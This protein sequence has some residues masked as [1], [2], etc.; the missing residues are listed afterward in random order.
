MRAVRSDRN[1]TAGL[2]AQ[3]PGARTTRFDRTPITPVVR[4]VP[5]LTV[6]CLANSSRRCHLRPPPSGPRVVTIAIRPSSLGRS[7]RNMRHF[8]ISVKAN[9]FSARLNRGL[10]CFARQAAQ[11]PVASRGI[12]YDGWLKGCRACSACMVRDARL[13]QAPHHEGLKS[14]PQKA[15]SS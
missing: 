7:G 6:A 13:R 4:A 12:A 1:I 10:A 9:I 11:Y 5:S 15:A 8:R 3:T 14:C 2:G